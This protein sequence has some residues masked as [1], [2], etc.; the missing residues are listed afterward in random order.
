MSKA[1][2]TR[3]DGVGCSKIKG[4]ANKWIAVEVGGVEGGIGM[5]DCLPYMVIRSPHSTP[6]SQLTTI[7]SDT[8]LTLDF[9][10]NQC[11]QKE[12]GRVLD[13]IQSTV[14]TSLDPQTVAETIWVDCH[15][16]T[17]GSILE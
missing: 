11:L 6:L 12:L 2:I 5:P 13:K 1:T 16:D 9:C 14:V 15:A 10:S 17:N 4:D 8:V 7:S 3:C